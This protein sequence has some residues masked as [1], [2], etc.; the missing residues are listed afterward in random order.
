MGHDSEAPPPPIME[1]VGR[2]SE[3]N[4][5]FDVEFW[6]KQGATAIFAAAWEIAVEAWQLK[7]NSES[8]PPFQR[9]V[10][11]VKRLER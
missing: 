2:V 11:S 8:E 5:R 1:R 6:Q 3:S 10:E 7:N 4:R 9:S